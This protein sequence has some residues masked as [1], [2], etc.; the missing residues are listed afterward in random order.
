MSLEKKVVWEI[1]GSVPGA[2][3]KIEL[4]W[5]TCLNELPNGNF[6]VGNCHAG[7]ESPQIFEINSGQIAVKIMGHRYS[8]PLGLM[9]RLP[10]P[11]AARFEE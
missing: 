11:F 7:P 8:M 10:I 1:K 6:V 2:H 9:I 4:K 3:G 5:T